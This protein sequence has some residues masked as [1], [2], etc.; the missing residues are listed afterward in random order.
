LRH[1]LDP[2]LR[3]KSVVV[4]GASEKSD[5]VGEWALLNLVKG[6]YKGII[7][8]VNPS[9]K[10]IQEIPC[11]NNL[12]DLPEIPDLAIIA[13]G[14]QRLELVFNEIVTLKI[15][16][17]VIFSSLVLDDDE[18]PF[19]KERLQKKISDS[20][21]LVCG[22]NGM[23]FYNIRDNVWACGFDSSSHYPPGNVS[24]ISHS[25]SGMSGIL[26][27]EARLR[28]NF[29]VSTGNE[30]SVT[31]DQYLDFVLDL[32]ETRVVGLFIETAR[33]PDGFILA[34]KKARDKK[35]PIVAL[36][37]GRTKKSA[38]L[39]L[40]HSGAMAGDDD[41]YDAI[42]DKYG[43]QRVRDMD[44]LATALI[45][46]SEFGLIGDGALVTLHDSGG[47][48][49]L[50]VDLADETKVPLTILD[51]NTV[52][53]LEKVIDPE[54]PAINPLD[55]WSRG[56]PNASQQYQKSTILMLGDPNTS[57]AALILDRA[58]K[59]LIYSDYIEYMKLAKAVHDK[60]IILVSSR[61]GTGSDCSV[62]ETTHAGYPVLDGVTNTLIGIKKLF[63]Y[64]DFFKRDT[65]HPI[66]IDDELIEHWQLRLRDNSVMSENDSLEL[67]SDFGIPVVSHQMAA[68]EKEVLK[69]ALEIGYPVVLKTAVFGLHHKSDKN[70]VIL[71][72]QSDQELLV[73]YKRMKMD[74]GCDVLIA[75][76]LL[77]G[78]EMILGVRR[79]PQFG[80]IVIL[81]MGGIY[82]E[83]MK[84]I[85]FAVPPFNKSYALELL[86]RLKF[87]KSLLGYRG[88][89][90]YDI[91][92]FCASAEK[93]SNMVH[94][95]RD[96]INELDI[97][98]LIINESGC[99]AVDA[100]AVGMKRVY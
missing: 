34:L 59:G 79:D 10:K 69:A 98:P 14:D 20:G 93:F 54:L 64:R 33:N 91:D 48:R 50:L 22:A 30:L 94:V 13:I 53:E 57:I 40:S 17:A 37:V 76:M 1:N 58:P 68:N 46:F 9:Y 45:L 83:L 70:G 95:L 4:I 31:M 36:K 42:F 24:L 12:Q 25:G 86:N 7:Y 47:E 61:Q 75:K 90:P 49:Q 35:I 66:A 26:D 89:Q 82:S 87:K 78:Q 96:V 52:V 77:P 56:G 51:E 62:I 15:K 18:Q 8:P 11:F 74:L 81:G 19:L 84:D 63:L 100:F 2:L 44:E 16:A 88:T 6:G 85:V 3:P 99:I 71:D 5:S 38:E 23:G 73:A 60:P 72:I 67:I 92:S 43:V 32:P 41:T 29:A 39:T 28:F 97:N 55:V 21:I 80:P 65:S 27:C